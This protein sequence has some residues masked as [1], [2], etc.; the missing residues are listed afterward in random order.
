MRESSK[1]LAIRLA[2]I[3]GGCLLQL[4]A[5]VLLF[6]FGPRGSS[7]APLLLTPL[8]VYIA[9]VPLKRKTKAL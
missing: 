8:L 3:L 2:L 9:V 7:L 5:V 6:L 4:I 1:E